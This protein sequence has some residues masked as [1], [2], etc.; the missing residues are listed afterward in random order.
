[1]ITYQEL[2]TTPEYWTTRIQIDLYR[3]IDEYLE[4]NHLTRKELA[5]KLGVTKGYVSQVMSGDFDHR[6]SKFVELSLAAGMIPQVSFVPMDKIFAKETT[7]GMSMKDICSAQK[8]L[9][10]SMKDF[11]NQTSSSTITY[12]ADSVIINLTEQFCKVA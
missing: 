3:V 11:D 9:P 1:M 5:A 4:S 2:L 6:L 12:T 10:C 7:A 8:S